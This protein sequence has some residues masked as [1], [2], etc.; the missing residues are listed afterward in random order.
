MIAPDSIDDGAAC[1]RSRRC[2]VG[3]F[4]EGG[5]RGVVEQHRLLNQLARG[6]V[7][8]LQGAELNCPESRGSASP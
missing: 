8:P 4:S 7:F 5:D 1:D 3:R 2:G 6:V